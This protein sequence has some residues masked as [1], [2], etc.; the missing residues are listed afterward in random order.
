MREGSLKTTAAYVAFISAEPG[1]WAHIDAAPTG[2][3]PAAAMTGKGA[4]PAPDS[5][6]GAGRLVAGSIESPE[7]VSSLALRLPADCFGRL[8]GYLGFEPRVA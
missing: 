1:F 2:D 8:E 7:L 5:G 4:D 3:V 6:P